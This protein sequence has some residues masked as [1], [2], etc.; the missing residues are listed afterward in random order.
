MLAA[1]GKAKLILESVKLKLF[2]LTTYGVAVKVL[3][4]MTSIWL[5]DPVTNADNSVSVLHSLN[6]VRFKAVP[7]VT[8]FSVSMIVEEII[9]A[10]ISLVL[11]RHV[12]EQ[13]QIGVGS[14]P[15]GL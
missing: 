13:K 1:V 5:I 12:V 9:T 15:N 11:L 10:V 2:T 8:S 14:V 4:V 7:A 3:P 6:E